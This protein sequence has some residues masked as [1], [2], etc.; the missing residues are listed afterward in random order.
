MNVRQTTDVPD[1]SED[2]APALTSAVPRPADAIEGKDTGTTGSDRTPIFGDL[3]AG[4]SL[5]TSSNWKWAKLFADRRAV[6]WE[7]PVLQSYHR[8]GLAQIFV[9]ARCGGRSLGATFD[10]IKGAV[11]ACLQQVWLSAELGSSSA[12]RIITRRDA[13]RRL[14]VAR[15]RARCDLRIHASALAPRQGLLRTTIPMRAV[16]G[17]GP[18]H[19]GA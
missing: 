13:E 9:F 15:R 11:N 12:F 1:R 5:A 10:M 19:R 4:T 2:K 8:S 18:G 16:P 17:A 14:A 3:I 6:I 7:T